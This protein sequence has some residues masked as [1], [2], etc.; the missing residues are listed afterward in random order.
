MFKGHESTRL[1]LNTKESPGITT[2]TF[3]G[4]ITEPVIFE[5]LKKKLGLIICNKRLMTTTLFF[6]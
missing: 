5:V 2:E 6:S 3:S 4:K 1:T